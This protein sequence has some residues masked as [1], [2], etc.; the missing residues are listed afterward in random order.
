MAFPTEIPENISDLLL[1]GGTVDIFLDPNSG[2]LDITSNTA[3]LSEEGGESVAQRLRIRLRLFYEEWILDRTA[4]TKWY[5]LILKK[6]ATK[7][8]IDRELRRRVMGTRDVV[9][10][11]TWVSSKN[12]RTREYTC[13]FS[14]LTTFDDILEFQLQDLVI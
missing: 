13:H 9:S 4:G 1:G 10:I 8:I 5:Q 11:E 12:D 2:D 3:R 6:E 14:V 7:L